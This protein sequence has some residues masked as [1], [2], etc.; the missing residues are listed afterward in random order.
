M[1]TRP[2]RQFYG[3][4]API[5]VSGDPDDV[6]G[7]WRRHRE[8]FTAVLASLDEAEWHAITRC[9]DWDARQVV[10]HLATADSFWTAS[11]NGAA[12]GSATSFLDGF[13]PTSTPDQII[14]AMADDP[15][16]AVLERFATTTTALMEAVESLSADAWSRTGESPLGH[17]PARLAL[18]HAHWDSWLHERDI[19][20]PLG[21]IPE[22]HPDEILVSAWY[23]LAAAG[24]QGGL[25]GGFGEAIDGPDQP[26]EATLQFEDLPDTS[27]S[28]RVTDR[29]AVE[30]GPDDPALQSNGSAVDLIEAFTGRRPT[31][32]L[33]LDGALLDQLARAREIL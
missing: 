17:V 26:I 11:L 33:P 23:S 15:P 13:D 29:V 30:I 22:T 9:D 28:I 25:V 10:N 5:E 1:G 27:L 14:A 18:A 21:K 20:V 3:E 8:R 4:P 32:G 12:A 19:L 6:A 7:P 31:I 16:A 2:L 24:L